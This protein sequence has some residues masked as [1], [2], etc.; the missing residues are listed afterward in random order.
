MD[1]TDFYPSHE[2]MAE[3]FAPEDVTGIGIVAYGREFEADVSV[4]R[5]EVC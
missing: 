1:F 2:G 5:V 3:G 4:R